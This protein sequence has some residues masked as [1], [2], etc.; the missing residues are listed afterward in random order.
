MNISITFSDD[1]SFTEDTLLV[2]EKLSEGKTTVYQIYSPLNKANYALKVFAKT[3]ANKILFQKEQLITTLSHPNIIKYIPIQHEF[4]DAYAHLTEFAKY[5]DF[6][7]L[8]SRSILNRN[9]VLVRTFFHH[10]IEGLEYIHSQGISHLDLKLENLVLGA[11][12]ML[13]I[14]DFDQAQP[15]IDEIMTSGGTPNYRAP[16]VLSGTCQDLSAVDV[17]S[18]GIILYILKSGEFPFIET[19]DNTGRVK[20]CCS[21]FLKN[22][23]EFWKNK[24]QLLGNEKIF[25]EDFIELV[26]GMLEYDPTK[27]LTIQDIKR[28]KWYKGQVLDNKSLRIRMK[29][30]WVNT[31][32]KECYNKASYTQVDKTRD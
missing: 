8:V 32:I 6:F 21:D 5:G 18:A 27:R 11:D 10:L 12:Y 31:K 29:A 4:S 25:N 24:A 15:I 28:S 16:E 2:K 30:S 14:I 19:Y 7:S 26:N 22:N 13:K 23:S 1:L 9:E 3:T 20:R 17:Y